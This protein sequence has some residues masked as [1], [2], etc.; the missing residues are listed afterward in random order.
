[1]TTVSIYRIMVVEPQEGGTY[2]IGKDYL[3]YDAAMRE[4]EGRYWPRVNTRANG[5]KTYPKGTTF[6]VVHVVT[7]ETIL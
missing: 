5:S 7:T 1:M 6:R 2:Q 4:I 3:T